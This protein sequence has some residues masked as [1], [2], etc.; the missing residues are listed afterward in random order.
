MKPKI[1]KADIAGY[2]V[3][4][5]NDDDVYYVGEAC[6]P[7]GNGFCYKDRAAFKD[8]QGICYT[9]EYS[10]MDEVG[11]D[12][13][14]SDEMLDFMNKN[15]IGYVALDNGYTFYDIEHCVYDWIG[16]KLN[17][18]ND[19]I[20]DLFVDYMCEQVFENVDWQCP[21]TYLQEL[22]V[23]EQWENAPQLSC[24]DPR[25]PHSNGE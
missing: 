15:G 17:E 1:I 16:D 3:K 22:D 5:P 18:L 2:M 4:F 25:F 13:N 10:F 12:E 20:Y 9:P 14:V 23:I 8:R 19:Y 11:I 7:I 24:I 21:E 6:P